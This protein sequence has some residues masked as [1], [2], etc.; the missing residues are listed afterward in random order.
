MNL[1]ESVYSCSYI[2]ILCSKVEDLGKNVGTYVT[3]G[4]CTL[5]YVQ[6]WV[7]HQITMLGSRT[8]PVP[9]LEFPQLCTKLWA[10]IVL[11]IHRF[12]ASNQVIQGVCRRTTKNAQQMMSNNAYKT[13]PNITPSF[14][15]N[16]TVNLCVEG[17]CQ[18]VFF[19]ALQVPVHQTIIINHQLTTSISTNHQLTTR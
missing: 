13:E 12:L 3:T 6:K 19:R 8:T 4:V 15:M 14:W 18:Q 9:V 5:T 10:S 1:Y 16:S 2:C 17:F 11:D 7:K